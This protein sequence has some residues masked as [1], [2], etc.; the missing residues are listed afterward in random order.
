MSHLFKTRSRNSAFTLVELLIVI[1]IIGILASLATVGVMKALEKGKMV[2]ARTEIS[3]LEAA[4]AAAKQNFGGVDNL[5]S[6]IKL[7]ST[8]AG[9]NTDALGVST[10]NFLTKAF[11]KAW[12]SSPASPWMGVGYTGTY[13]VT[14]TGMEAL[15]FWL[16]GVRDANGTFQGFSSYPS[17]PW[18]ITNTKRKGPFYEFDAVRVLNNTPT[19]IPTFV[20][21]WNGSYAYFSSSDY[22]NFSKTVANGG[23]GAYSATGGLISPLLIRT[24]TAFYNPKTF[25]II[26]SGPDQSFGKGNFGGGTTFGVVHTPGSGDYAISAPGYDDLAN[27]SSTQLGKKDE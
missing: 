12:Q 9:F 1:A 11:G 18:D 14:L 7:Y 4:I 5:P 20:N 26:S 27:F 21:S 10:S 6:A 19:T 2:A 3:Q 24:P 17:T 16:G 8:P 25:Q 13:P 22:L 15:V 23:Y